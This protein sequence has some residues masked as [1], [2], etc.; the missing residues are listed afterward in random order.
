MSRYT[1]SRDLLQSTL[2]VRSNAAVPN[3]HSNDLAAA[4]QG[5]VSV[6]R[7]SF[8]LW[9]KPESEEKSVLERSK[10]KRALAEPFTG[11]EAPILFTG[12]TLLHSDHY[13]TGTMLTLSIQ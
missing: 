6:V 8:D 9:P 5:I 12:L 7:S 13:D 11:P 2:V 10:I 3:L 4:T 1:A